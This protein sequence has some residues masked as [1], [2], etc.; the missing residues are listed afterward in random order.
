MDD[1]DP[2][3][4]GPHGRSLEDEIIGG[5]EYLRRLGVD[6]AQS[7]LDADT[8]RDAK[9][10]VQ[11][12]EAKKRMR[13]S[14]EA[15]GLSVQGIEAAMAAWEKEYDRA[16]ADGNVHDG[17]EQSEDMDDHDPAPD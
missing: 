2:G 9:L 1:H 13:A 17:E 3:D 12:D 14:F 7:A 16:Q 8:E 15:A 6:P 4:K 5:A 11:R 10:R